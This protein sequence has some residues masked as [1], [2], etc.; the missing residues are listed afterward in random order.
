[1]TLGGFEKLIPNH[2]LVQ[3]ATQHQ[4]PPNKHFWPLMDF[5]G[6]SSQKGVLRRNLLGV[7]WHLHHEINLFTIIT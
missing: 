7:L 2:F 4:L 3:H 5:L 1:M 6:H